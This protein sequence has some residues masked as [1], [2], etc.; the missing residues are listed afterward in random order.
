M[1]RSDRFVHW[2]GGVVCSGE[3]TGAHKERGRNLTASIS[4]CFLEKSCPVSYV[5]TM[6][7]IEP[8]HKR[9]VTDSDIEQGAGIRNGGFDFKMVA[10]D[11]WISHEP[12]AVF[13]SVFGDS[14]DCELIVCGAET[15]SLRK[16][17]QPA[18]ASL[19]DF[20]HQALE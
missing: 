11:T 1:E 6:M 4:E 13:V 5:Q 2:A 7:L 18:K 14:L 16:Y 8:S 15:S 17:R 20:Q 10:N 3:I 19:V 9:S 12:N